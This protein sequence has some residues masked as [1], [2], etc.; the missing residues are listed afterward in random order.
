MKKLLVIGIII[1]FIVISVLPCVSSKDESNSNG[2]IEKDYDSGVWNLGFIL[3]RLVEIE[4]GTW[5]VY[6]YPG[7]SV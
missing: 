4:L 5:Y 7:Q 2:L 3:C 6:G 1:L